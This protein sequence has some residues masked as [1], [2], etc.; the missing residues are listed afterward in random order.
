MQT[1][2]CT[3]KKAIKVAIQKKK[4]PLAAHFSAEKPLDKFIRLR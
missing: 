4:S 2:P 3:N 1:L